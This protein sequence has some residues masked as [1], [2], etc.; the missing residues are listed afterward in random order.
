[1][2]IPKAN[3]H[4]AAVGRIKG[5]S[6]Y[7][8]EGITLYTERLKPYANIEITEVAEEAL[9]ATKTEAQI[10]AREA[11]KLAP[12]IQKAS[13]CVVLS[14]HGPVW[15][16]GRLAQQL[17]SWVEASGRGTGR[18]NPSNGGASPTAS[19][20]IIFVIGGPL[21]VDTRLLQQAQATLSLS[22]LTF[23]HQMVRLL[24]LE[25][26]YRSFKI[27]RNEPYHK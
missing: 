19:G 21:G 18:A 10:K 12:F 2:A 20:P 27:L 4:L 23:P 13:V 25:Q 22:P 15:H 16:S 1:M 9:T 5:S 6:A 26:L 8:K 11:E 24:L 17:A 7:L 14:E 3:I